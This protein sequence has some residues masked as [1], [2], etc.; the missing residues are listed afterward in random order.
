MTGLREFFGILDVRDFDRRTVVGGPV[1]HN[2]LTLKNVSPVPLAELTVD[3]TAALTRDAEHQRARTI[4]TAWGLTHYLLVG[5]G[6]AMRPALAAFIDAVER[7]TPSAAAFRQVFGTISRPSERGSRSPEPEEAAGVGAGVERRPA[8]GRGA[9][10]RSRRAR[11][12]GRPAGAQRRAR[13]CR[14]AAGSRAIHRSGHLGAQVARVR[15]R[16][17]QERVPEALDLLGQGALAGSERVDVQ[18][19][20]AQVLREAGRFAESVA[21]YRQ[22]VTLQPS[23]PFVHTA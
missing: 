17:A 4:A 16:L 15:Q 6:G 23:S 1:V 18:L 9:D 14:A 5:K 20:R 13:G 21:V 19:L 7:G 22:L 11:A 2:V 3:D 10:A 8:A 12:A